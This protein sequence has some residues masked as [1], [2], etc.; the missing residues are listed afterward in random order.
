MNVSELTEI[1]AYHLDRLIDFGPGTPGAL[2]WKHD[3]N[4]ELRLEAFSNL[5]DFNGH[6]VLDVGCGHGD[7]RVVL[8]KRYD[9]FHYTGIDQMQPFLDVAIQRHGKA[10]N[11]DF[12]LGDFTA[13][14]LP[15]ADYVIASGALSYRCEAPNFIFAMLNK[16]YDC[17]AIGLGFNLL[18]R[19]DFSAGI[20]V[21]YDP[22]VIL[23]Y[24]QSLSSR[25]ELHSDCVGADFTVFLHK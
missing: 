5:G 14:E 10:A 20:L 2:G 8:A 16:L 7:L 13:D 22:A 1:Q 15:K 11:T 12:L 18:S 23:A 17:S 25:V 3:E 4:H 6:S 9:R 19:V 24:C 21:A